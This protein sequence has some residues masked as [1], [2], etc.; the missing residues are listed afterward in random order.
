MIK[1]AHRGNLYGPIHQQENHPHYLMQAIDLG[2]DV[3]VDIWSLNNSLFLGHDLPKIPI[4]ES[5]VKDISDKAWFHCKNLG[6]LEWFIK[7]KPKYRYF[8]HQKDD[9][10]LTSNGLIWTYPGKEITNKSIIVLPKPDNL[11]KYKNAYGVCSDYLL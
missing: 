9:Y 1:I 7:Y 3:E 5:F 10:T 8:W 4:V 2:F 11:E 6:A